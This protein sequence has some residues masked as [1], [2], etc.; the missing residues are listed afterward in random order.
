MSDCLFYTLMEAA[1]KLRRS[2]RSIERLIAAR[3]LR[4]DPTSYKVLIPVED[5][6]NFF[7]NNGKRFPA[8]AAAVKG[9]TLAPA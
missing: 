2:T 6:D 5:V 1:V 3:Q 8:Q 4:R 9:S 7:A